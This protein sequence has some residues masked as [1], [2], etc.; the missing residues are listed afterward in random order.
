[1]T[2][3]ELITGILIAALALGSAVML[4]CCLRVADDEEE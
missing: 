3:R 4:W 1:M 2:M